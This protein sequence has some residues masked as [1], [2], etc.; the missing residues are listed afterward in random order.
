MTR[1]TGRLGLLVGLLALALQPCRAERE[2]VHHDASWQPEYVLVATAGNITLNC[3]SRYSVTYNGT[4]PGPTLYMREGK[5]TWV[6]VYNNMTDQNVT[7]VGLPLMCPSPLAPLFPCAAAVAELGHSIGTGS[8]R[9]WRPSRMARLSSLSG[10]LLPVNT[11]TMRSAQRSA[12][13]G[14]TFSTRTYSSKP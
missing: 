3:E 10:Q 13:R 2:A 9:G 11:S 7:T 6:R 14:P 1:S 12:T 8:A 5:T 4:S